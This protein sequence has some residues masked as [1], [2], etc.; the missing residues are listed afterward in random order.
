M[1]N[2]KRNTM[3]KKLVIT[4]AAVGILFGSNSATAQVE[5][6]NFLI[7]AYVG[8]PTSNVTSIYTSYTD[9]KTVGPPISFGARFEYMAAD[10]FGIGIDANYAITGSEYT[11]D[12]SN[13]SIYANGTIVKREVNK[14][15]IMVRG[16]FHF[17]QTE[18]LDVYGG[19]GIGFKNKAR[20]FSLNGV[21][22]PHIWLIAKPLP[23]AFR[24]AFGLRYYFHPNIG[25]SLEAGAGGGG[26]LQGG[27]ALK[28]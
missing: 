3:K 17:V 8:G 1:T 15:R 19:L 23:I 26:L 25:I 12:S 18:N 21:E 10:N 22:T 11:A 14:L 7:D 2:F 6:G 27:L 13:L 28:F 20:T 16:N 4:L 9:Y 24:A 5:Q